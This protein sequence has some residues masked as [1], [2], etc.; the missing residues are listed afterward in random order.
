MFHD[1]TAHFLAFLAEKLRELG[2][3]EKFVSNFSIEKGTKIDI[4]LTYCDR[5]N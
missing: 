3:I 1:E 5:G 4:K 2:Y